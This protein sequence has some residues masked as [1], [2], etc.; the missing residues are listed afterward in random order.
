VLKCIKLD[1]SRTV[2]IVVFSLRF[3]RQAEYSTRR[4]HEVARKW[5][6]RAKEP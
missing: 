4:S 5:V 1:A 3:Q 6:Q 2:L